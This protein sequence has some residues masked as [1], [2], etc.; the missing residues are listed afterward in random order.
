MEIVNEN[1]TGIR[2]CS[3]MHLI[4]QMKDRLSSITDWAVVPNQACSPCPSESRRFR[5]LSEMPSGRNNRPILLS[6]RQGLR[7]RAG[8]REGWNKKK[9]KKRKKKRKRTCQKI[10][11]NH[12]F[13]ANCT[14]RISRKQTAL[15]DSCEN[16]ILIRPR[17]YSP[18]PVLLQER[19]AQNLQV[20]GNSVYNL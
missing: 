14:T 2:N 19:F 18:P 10:L 6:C 4:S 12:G 8:V 16:F 13:Q 11:Y 5:E 3:P 9:K 7:S 15:P 20:K 1:W 17:L